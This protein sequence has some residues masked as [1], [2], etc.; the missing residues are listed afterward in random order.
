MV[1]L[2]PYYHVNASDLAHE[3][4]LL[5]KLDGEEE[6]LNDDNIYNMIACL[7]RVITDMEE[8]SFVYVSYDWLIKISNESSLPHY[9]WLGKYI[10]KAIMKDNPLTLNMEDVFCIIF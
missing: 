10:V 4:C 6:Y 9:K 3:I 2:K 8:T 7:F 5:R 1:E